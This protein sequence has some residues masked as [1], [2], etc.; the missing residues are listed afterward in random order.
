MAIPIT[1][2]L[3][4]KTLLDPD[5]QDIL[6]ET[7]LIRTQMEY[8]MPPGDGEEVTIMTMDE[9]DEVHFTFYA[10]PLGLFTPDS[11]FIVIMLSN[12]NSPPDEKIIFSYHA[13]VLL[14]RSSCFGVPPAVTHQT[15]TLTTWPPMGCL[16]C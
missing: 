14:L 15:T 4:C 16:T 13:F 8:E 7:R 10:M 5:N 6:I 9:D 3:I 11:V 12:D 1:Q 2:E